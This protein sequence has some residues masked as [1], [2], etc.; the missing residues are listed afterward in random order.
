MGRPRVPW[1]VARA[2]LLAV[3]QGNGLVRQ[4]L[5]KGTDLS[6]HTQNDLDK[7]AQSPNTR[8]RMTLDWETPAERLNQLVATNP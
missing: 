6:I 8:P 4:Y 7:M 1:L 5:P 2:A 3:G